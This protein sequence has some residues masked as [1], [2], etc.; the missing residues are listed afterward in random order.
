M[1]LIKQ[2]LLE[3]FMGG[4]PV[5]EVTPKFAQE[6]FELMTSNGSTLLRCIMAEE[7]RGIGDVNIN[8]VHGTHLLP[9]AAIQHAQS[10]QLCT[11]RATVNLFNDEE[12]AALLLTAE[13]QILLTDKAVIKSQQ[14]ASERKTQYLSTAMYNL[15]NALYPP[16]P[17]SATRS[18][19]NH[20]TI[21]LSHIVPDVY[22]MH[23]SYHQMQPPPHLLLPTLLPFQQRAVGWMLD[24]EG[25]IVNGEGALVPRGGDTSQEPLMLEKIVTEKGN[26][27][28][29]HRLTGAVGLK[30]WVF[31]DNDQ[32]VL[33]GILADEVIRTKSERRDCRSRLAYRGWRTD[34]LGEDGYAASFDGTASSK[35][36]FCS[37]IRL[38]NIFGYNIEAGQTPRKER[39]Q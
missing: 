3:S 16:T 32:E 11:L 7:G 38:G 21:L 22:P 35:R 24:R 20:V 37:K 15:I 5:W 9:L 12:E 28:Y 17:I 25:V 36:N 31:E 1:E 4:E 10:Q 6:A 27:V 19:P 26:V 18:Q 14:E 34:G 2:R 30:P 23:A 39:K 13:I 33:G 29:L 8:L